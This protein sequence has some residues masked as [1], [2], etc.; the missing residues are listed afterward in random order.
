MIEKQIPIYP[1][2]ITR[3]GL[4]AVTG[5]SDRHVRIAINKARK[6]GWPIVNFQDGK[7]YSMADGDAEIRRQISLNISRIADLALQNA[8]LQKHI[9]E[10]DGQEKLGV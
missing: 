4:R 9:R 1:D 8:K 5:L 6:D 7:G 2:A 10:I 3:D